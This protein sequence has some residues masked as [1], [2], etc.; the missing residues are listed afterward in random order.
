MDL[1]SGYWEIPMKKEGF[2]KTASKTDNGLFEFNVLPYSL[3]NAPATFQ[4]LMNNL[5]REY[6][7]ITVRFTLTT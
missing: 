5:L 1:K 6:L 2:L 7:M 3:V 4:K